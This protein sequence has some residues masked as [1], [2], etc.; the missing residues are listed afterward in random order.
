MPRLKED[1]STLPVLLT[2]ELPAYEVKTGNWRSIRPVIHKEKC[3]GCALC[4]KFCPDACITLKDGKPDIS[5]DHCKGCGVCATECPT[6]CITMVDEASESVG[7]A[8]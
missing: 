4:W 3:T 6:N 1:P 2:G 8:I 7:E 5:F